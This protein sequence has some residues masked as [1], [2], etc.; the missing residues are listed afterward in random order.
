MDRVFQ[1][2]LIWFLGCL[3]YAVLGIVLFT[4]FWSGVI[5]VVAFFV[6]WLGDTRLNVD[7]VGFV[8]RFVALLAIPF[9]WGNRELRGEFWILFRYGDVGNVLAKKIGKRKSC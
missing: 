8:D 7:T 3:V 9:V 4:G 5:V 2:N 1:R 6:W